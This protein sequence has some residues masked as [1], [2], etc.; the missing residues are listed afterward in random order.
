MST[1]SGFYIA[2][3]GIQAA[4]ASLNITGQ[5]MANVNTEGYTRE[6]LD[7]YSVGSSAGGMRYSSRD[8]AIGGGVDSHGATQVR[9]QY[10][11][12]HYRV[13]NAKVG[14]PSA[15]VD[16]L[17][18]LE[19]IFDETTN[20]GLDS[21]FKD[22]ISKLSTF[23]GSSTDPVTENSVKNSCQLLVQAFNDT[24]KQIDQIRDQQVDSMGTNCVDKVN[25]LLSGIANINTEIKS[26][27]LSGSP[28][29]SLLD[30]RNSMIDQLSNYM[31]IEVSSSSV[32]VGAGNSVNVLSINLVSGNQKFNL[33]DDNNYK[34]LDLAKDS[35]SNVTFP[36]TVKLEDSSGAPVAKSN[37]GSVTLTG[38]DIN[39]YLTTG[40]IGGSLKQLN[41]KGDFATGTQSTERGI[42]Y[43]QGMLDSL[44][45]SFSDMMNN[46][47]STVAGG[48]NKPL[49]TQRDGTTTTGIT[50]ANITLSS[51]WK[52]AT[53]C[54]MT[55]TRD[56]GAAGSN[57]LYMVNQFSVKNTYTTPGGKG[58]FTGTFQESVTNID[59]TMG[60][61]LSDAKRQASSYQST[62]DDINDKRNAIS[63]VD[64]NEEGINLLMYNQALTASSRVMTTLNEALDTIINKM[65][66]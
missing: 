40:Y 35:Q 57:I 15:Q 61:Q 64:S 48:N 17:T 33:V 39:D 19:S 14:D 1:F 25:S 7:T 31:N 16:S 51:A 32:D 28:A 20:K 5:N 21:Q 2:R 50:A 22:L 44:A 59:T 66:V 56:A 49:L 6:R 29:L 10:L 60:L 34:Q 18:S 55:S 52:N 53:G 47:N 43:Y 26:S 65:G 45:Q 27:E 13:Q 62:L 36:V 24:S 30:Q 38:G 11:D 4:Q 23:A 41:G 3:S 63:S 9:D 42:D 58:F 37:D 8:G 54:Y 46:A 12:V